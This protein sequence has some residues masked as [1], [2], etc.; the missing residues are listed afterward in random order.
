MVETLNDVSITTMTTTYSD[1]SVVTQKAGGD[2][3]NDSG[4][5]EGTSDAQPND[6]DPSRGGG[7]GMPNPDDTGGDNESAPSA[8]ALL[9]RPNVGPPRRRRGR[10][11]RELLGYPD[12][13]STGGVGPRGRLFMPNP[14]DS[15]GTGGPRGFYATP[16]PDDVGGVGGPR[17]L[18]EMP[19]PDDAS[20]IGG[21]RGFADRPNPE[22]T[23]SPTGPNTRIGVRTIGDLLGGARS[24][25]LM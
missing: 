15:S 18:Y 1:G 19:N 9:F 13:D 12:P 10:G 11:A 17:G 23:R 3:L 21:P 2:A 20:G 8:Q 14:D 6:T 5:P 7:G 25:R 4:L 16:N 22:D 24:G